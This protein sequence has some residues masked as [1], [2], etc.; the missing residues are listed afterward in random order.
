MHLVNRNFNTYGKKCQQNMLGLS[1]KD[2]GVMKLSEIS[3]SYTYQKEAY[4]QIK[5]GSKE[6]TAYSAV[7]LI[8][9]L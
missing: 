3:N 9:F 6:K 1:F 7:P 8:R 2:S 4:R 5:A